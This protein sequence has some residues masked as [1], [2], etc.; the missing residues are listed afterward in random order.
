[1]FEGGGVGPEEVD[2]ATDSKRVQLQAVSMTTFHLE[3]MQRNK[4]NR[5]GNGCET[6][7][8]VS[9]VSQPQLCPSQEARIHPHAPP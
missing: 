2:I 9:T 1:M 7:R 5:L 6:V 3:S 8:T 4:E